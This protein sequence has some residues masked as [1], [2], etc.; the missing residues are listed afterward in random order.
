MYEKHEQL[1]DLDEECTLWKYMNF[2]KF[3]NMLKGKLYFNRLDNF[4][5]VF[6][7]HFHNSM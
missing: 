7:E 5:D 3:I 1:F 2:S 4:E 6:E